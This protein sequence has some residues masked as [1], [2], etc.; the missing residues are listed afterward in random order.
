MQSVHATASDK[1]YGWWESAALPCFVMVP[2]CSPEVLGCSTMFG[3]GWRTSFCLD[4]SFSAARFGG[5]LQFH[6]DRGYFQ[7]SHGFVSVGLLELGGECL[8]TKHVLC[9]E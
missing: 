2:R 6:F 1:R 5:A 7:D 8:L 4:G 9:R 3:S